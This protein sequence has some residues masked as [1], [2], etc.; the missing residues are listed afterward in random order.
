MVLGRPV[1]PGTLLAES[2]KFQLNLYGEVPPVAVEVKLIESP[3]TGRG[4]AY[5][6]L[7]C[8]ARF[9]KNWVMVDA[10][11]SF[12][13]RGERPHAGSRVVSTEWWVYDF[14]DWNFV[15]AMGHAQMTG[16]LP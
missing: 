14:D 12:E 9:L 16:R 10:E 13:V 15:L 6:R 1:P 3:T 4:G 11:P 8:G 2:P 5:E 7:V